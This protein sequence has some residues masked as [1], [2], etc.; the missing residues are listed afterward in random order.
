[1]AE[2]TLG[3]EIGRV[4]SKDE[5]DRKLDEELK[6]AGMGIK[7]LDSFAGSAEE[8]LEKLRAIICSLIELTSELNSETLKENPG[9]FQKTEEAIEMKKAE[10]EV[11]YITYKAQVEIQYPHVPISQKIAVFILGMLRGAVREP[12]MLQT[13]GGNK[14]KRKMLLDAGSGLEVTMKETV[15]RMTEKAQAARSAIQNEK[16]QAEQKIEREKREEREALEKKRK[17]FIDVRTAE[18]LRE[19]KEYQ[20]IVANLDNA[21]KEYNSSRYGM[22][23][24]TQHAMNARA[25]DWKTKKERKEKEARSQAEAELFKKEHRETPT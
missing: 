24:K 7:D 10:F 16:Y 25:E 1:M 11:L 15:K 19:N 4:R 2:R 14:R 3:Q 9:V 13:F 20:E 5:V 8:A 21:I 23:Q 12:V 6:A 22:D 18:I 17:E